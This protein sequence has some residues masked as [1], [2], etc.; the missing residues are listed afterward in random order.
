[1][2]K[3]PVFRKRNRTIWLEM[4]NPGDSWGVIAEESPNRQ[5][6]WDR[7]TI[8]VPIE[9]LRNAVAKVTIQHEVVGMRLK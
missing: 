1:M 6:H 8:R 9:G 3:Y 5:G 7:N 4:E 2:V